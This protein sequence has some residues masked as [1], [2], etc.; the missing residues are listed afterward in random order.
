[1]YIDTFLLVSYSLRVRT[2]AVRLLA[3][4]VACCV[5]GQVKAEEDTKRLAQI[6]RDADAQVTTDVFSECFSCPAEYE[7]LQGISSYRALHDPRAHIIC[8]CCSQMAERTVYVEQRLKELEAQETQLS[9][10]A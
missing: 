6:A 9:S 8:C 4:Y 3:N 1:M 7:C 2:C 10:K 5:C